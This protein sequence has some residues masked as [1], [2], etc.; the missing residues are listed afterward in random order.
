MNCSY[1]DAQCNTPKIFD[2]L[3][4]TSRRPR[5][6]DH[7]Y[8]IDEDDDDDNDDDNWA[9]ED[10]LIVTPHGV[11]YATMICRSSVTDDPRSALPRHSTSLP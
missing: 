5:P 8:D 9:L 4:K 10:T 11:C 2:R 1:T 6:T 3:A 7:H